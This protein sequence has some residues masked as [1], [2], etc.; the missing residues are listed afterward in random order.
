MF[1][2]LFPI[3][4]ELYKVGVFSIISENRERNQQTKHAQSL[5]K[6]ACGRLNI[7]K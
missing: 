2:I 7:I 5:L 6:N 3:F 4:K 1:F